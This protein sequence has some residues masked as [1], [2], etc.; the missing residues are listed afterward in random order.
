MDDRGKGLQY[1]VRPISKVSGSL[2]LQLRANCVR[3]AVGGFVKSYLFELQV[4]SVSVPVDGVQ[5]IKSD[6]GEVF[7]CGN[8][9]KNDGFMVGE[10]C[11]KLDNGSITSE[12]KEGVIP[13]VD[14][15]GFGQF[16]DL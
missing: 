16:L 1:A 6:T 14:Q 5:E 8:P 7:S 2:A 11:Q 10:R 15:M 13:L 9:V 3:P 12:C 4:I